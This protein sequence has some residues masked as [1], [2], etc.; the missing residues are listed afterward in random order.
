MRLGQGCREWEFCKWRHLYGRRGEQ[1]GDHPLP[2]PFQSQWALHPHCVS[3]RMHSTI[4]LPS[5]LGCC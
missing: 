3:T 2:Q 1:V 5:T 4:P